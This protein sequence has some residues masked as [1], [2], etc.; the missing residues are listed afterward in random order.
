[1]YIQVKHKK[2]EVSYK[3]NF[4]KKVQEFIETQKIK[5][6]KVA[7]VTDTNIYS[8]YPKLFKNK[9]ITVIL[10]KPGETSK[11]AKTKI[12]IE[13]KLFSNGFNRKSSIIA[14]GGGVVGDLAGFIASTFMRGIDLFHIPTSLIAIV[15]SSI[16]GKTAI[17]N[18]FGKNLVGT[19][20]NPKEILI[21]LDFINPLP[22]KEVRQGMAEIIKYA[23]IK[24]SRL[25]ENLETIN[26]KFLTNTKATIKNIIRKCIN[27]KV[28]TV[29]EDFKEGDKRMILN[30][31]HTV[32]HAL[33]KFN[34]YK[35]AH[36]DCI[37]IGMLIE[38]KISTKVHNLTNSDYI[39]VK[40]ILIKYKLLNL[41]IL[42]KDIKA[43]VGLMKLDKKNKSTKITFS[44]PKKIG[45]MQKKKGSFSVEINE[46]LI[47]TSIKEVL[48]E[49]KN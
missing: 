15:D 21:N 2:E 14:I 49:F 39:R 37:G 32:G 38:A 43:L 24:D 5:Y 45:I 18:K 31:G 27:I 41:K 46:S 48:D 42:N 36:G 34:N 11:S 13:D 26:T 20:Y 25:F 29:Q 23:I 4:S 6:S 30:F 12:T 44:L 1:M 10:I 16:G 9:G 3:I 8:L 28:H 22:D 33:E 35:E 47:K 17:D 40:E 19:F 7:L